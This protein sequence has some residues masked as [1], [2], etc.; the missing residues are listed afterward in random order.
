MVL[1]FFAASADSN[2]LDMEVEQEPEVQ[3]QQQP[4]PI[5]PLANPRKQQPPRSRLKQMHYFT[6]S[7]NSRGQPSRSSQGSRGSRKYRT[8]SRSSS[9]RQNIASASS[10]DSPQF[11]KSSVSLEKPEVN[12]ATNV[13]ASTSGLHFDLPTIR[14]DLELL[15]KSTEDKDDE[16]TIRPP[17]QDVFRVHK[18]QFHIS[19]ENVW[20]PRLEIARGGVCGGDYDFVE[21]ESMLVEC[22]G[23]ES[24]NENGEESTTLAEEEVEVKLPCKSVSINVVGMPSSSEVNSRP[25][26]ASLPL[27]VTDIN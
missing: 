22:N 27:E 10:F 13:T 25:P 15:K 23:C 6:W 7:A 11:S 4:D 26:P 16:K 12:A 24:S 19:T 8:A 14:K 3:Q 1:L 18:P 2:S 5:H 9:R 17:Q 21:N 20:F